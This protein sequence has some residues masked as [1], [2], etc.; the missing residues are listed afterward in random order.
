MAQRRKLMVVSNIHTNHLDI[1]VGT[2]YYV[3]KT[4]NSKNRKVTLFDHEPGALGT[5]KKRS[6]RPYARTV[7]GYCLKPLRFPA[8]PKSST[9]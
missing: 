3:A 8:K 2:G 4:P 6:G 9:A 5:T 1:G 7:V